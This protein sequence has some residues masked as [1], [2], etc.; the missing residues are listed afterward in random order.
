MLVYSYPMCWSALCT[1]F[2]KWSDKNR[3]GA[4]RLFIASWG[5]MVWLRQLYKLSYN[6]RL[7]SGYQRLR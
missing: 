4:Y 6:R 3:R 1:V 2:S 5:V 7:R